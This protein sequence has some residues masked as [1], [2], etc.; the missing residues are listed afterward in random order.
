M[1]YLSFFLGIGAGAILM[2]AVAQWWKDDCER[3]HVLPWP[4]CLA[5]YSTRHRTP[6]P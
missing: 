1:G 2:L 5:W 4:L 3:G 6:P